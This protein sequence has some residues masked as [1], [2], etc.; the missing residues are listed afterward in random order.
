MLIERT[1]P[2]FQD[3]LCFPGGHVERG[4]TEFLAV[5][6][7][8]RE[9]VGIAFSP[10]DVWPLMELNAP[11]RDPRPG[12]DRAVVFTAHITREKFNHCC[13]A[14]SDAK[15]VCLRRLD[16]LNEHELGFDH[17]L[18]IEEIRK[19]QQARATKRSGR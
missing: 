2:P 13:Q 5:I 11:G 6:R 9:E 15:S 17:F 10:N 4:E 12:H 14:G 3:K 16:E 1:K 19:R 7:E 8:A 18:A